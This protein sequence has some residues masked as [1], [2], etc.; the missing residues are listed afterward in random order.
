MMAEGCGCAADATLCAAVWIVWRGWDDPR[1][2][3]LLRASVLM[4]CAAVFRCAERAS[5]SETATS[6]AA[7]TFL[8]L[9][10]QLRRVAPPPSFPPRPSVQRNTDPP[11]A[12]LPP[13]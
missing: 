1:Q 2:S 7:K 13:V 8:K 9:L 4:T 6:F 10:Q 12:P 5:P 11:F 3:L